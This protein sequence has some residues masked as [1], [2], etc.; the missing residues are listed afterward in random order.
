MS[1]SSLR[2][3]FG[4]LLRPLSLL[5]AV[6][7]FVFGCYMVYAS[8]FGDPLFSL[9]TGV[10]WAGFGVLLILQSV[11]YLTTGRTPTGG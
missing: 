10:W 2:R 9:V 4:K 3:T 6:C 5:S 11:W 8:V 7:G 1:E